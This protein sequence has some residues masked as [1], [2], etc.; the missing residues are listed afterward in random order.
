MERGI[1]SA[2][3][4]VSLHNQLRSLVAGGRERRGVGG[5]QPPAAD[6]MMLVSIDNRKKERNSNS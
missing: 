6:M 4:I 5:T 3:E 2:A 1:S